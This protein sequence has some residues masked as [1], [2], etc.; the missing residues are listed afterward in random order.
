MIGKTTVVEAIVVTGVVLIGGSGLLSPNTQSTK[1][2]ELGQF[3]C[4]GF[5]YPYVAKCEGLLPY[6]VWHAATGT[7]LTLDV[8]GFCGGLFASDIQRAHPLLLGQLAC[9]G[10]TYP[11]IEKCS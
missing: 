1:P 2:L 10:V 7:Q 3:A 9:V 4:V 11:Y 5:I 6:N 8:V